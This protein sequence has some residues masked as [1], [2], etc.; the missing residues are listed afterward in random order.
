MRMS[1]EWSLKQNHSARGELIAEALALA[2]QNP[3]P[4]LALSSESLNTIAPL[5]PTTL[6]TAGG[7]VLYL[8]QNGVTAA[9]VTTEPAARILIERPRTMQS[10]P[11]VARQIAAVANRLTVAEVTI[12]RKV[13]AP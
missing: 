6:P 8:L 11:M 5:L 1:P 2:W 10:N 4:L 12:I 13:K 3:A 7:G 9:N